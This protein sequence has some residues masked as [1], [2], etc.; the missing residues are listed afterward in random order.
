MG[1]AVNVVSG[2]KRDVEKIGSFR[3]HSLG[4]CRSV[5]IRP[6]KIQPKEIFMTLNWPK[7]AILPILLA[8]LVEL[9]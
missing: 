2:I 4:D 3:N 5:V 9:T 7:I 6:A 1:C 8:I